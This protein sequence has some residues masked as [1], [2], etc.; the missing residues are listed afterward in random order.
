LSLAVFAK[1][2]AAENELNPVKDRMKRSR[3][4]H[5][6]N[7]ELDFVLFQRFVKTGNLHVIIAVTI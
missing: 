3:A 2:Q 6:A 1:N 7:V 4:G 5:A